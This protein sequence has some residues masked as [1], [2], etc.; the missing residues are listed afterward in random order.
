MILFEPVDKKKLRQPNFNNIP[1]H[2]SENGKRPRNRRSISLPIF[3]FPP[4]QKNPR[5]IRAKTKS[6][7]PPRAVPAVRN[8]TRSKKSDTSPHSQNESSTRDWMPPKP[9]KLRPRQRRSR[10]STELNLDMKSMEMML[11]DIE[12]ATSNLLRQENIDE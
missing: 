8:I 5:S 4:E 1:H 7:S 10:H 3:D 2:D 11:T 6:A 12:K 9:L